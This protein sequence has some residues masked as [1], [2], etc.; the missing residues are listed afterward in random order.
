MQATK[1]DCGIQI[2]LVLLNLQ[3]NAVN[4]ERFT[5]DRPEELTAYQ[6]ANERASATVATNS[7]ERK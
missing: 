5:S 2:L 7:L 4:K 6:S 3:P 1:F